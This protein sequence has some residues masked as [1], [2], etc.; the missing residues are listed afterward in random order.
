MNTDIDYT[1]ENIRLLEVRTKND[2]W[3][4]VTLYQYRKEDDTD[5]DYINEWVESVN[6]EWDYGAYAGSCYVCFI[7]KKE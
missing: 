4:W 3:Y 6:G 1:D 2:G 5:P 7:H